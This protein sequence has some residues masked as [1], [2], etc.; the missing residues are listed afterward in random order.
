[1]DSTVSLTLSERMER[2]AQAHG[3][4]CVRVRRPVV[5]EGSRSVWVRH[6]LTDGERVVAH[7]GLGHRTLFWRRADT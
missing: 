5:R 1:M 7:Y 2:L 3:L 4:K 6:E